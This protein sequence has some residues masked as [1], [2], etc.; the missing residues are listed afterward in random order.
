MF[1]RSFAEYNASVNILFLVHFLTGSYIQK[2]KT[3]SVTNQSAIKIAFVLEDTQSEDQLK[4]AFDDFLKENNNYLY[5]VVGITVKWNRKDTPGSIWTEIEENLVNQNVTLVISFLPSCTNQLL[6]DALSKSIVP[7]IG[8]QSQR[9]ELYS[10]NKV[11]YS[12]SPHHLKT[13]QSPKFVF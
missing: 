11:S 10:N 2:C 12:S 4:T 13:E 5:S 9:E 7:I 3:S 1:W 6:V 8:L